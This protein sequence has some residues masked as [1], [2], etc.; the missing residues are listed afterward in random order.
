MLEVHLF[1][2]FAIQHDGKP[3]VLSSRAAQSLFAYLVLRAGSQHRREKLAGMFWPDESEE[4]ARAYLRHELWRIRKALPAVQF[5]HSNDIDISFDPPVQLW[6]DAKLLMDLK[7]SA[8]I[9]ELLSALTACQG[10]FLSGF[11]DEWVLPEREH[12][13]ALYQQAMDRLLALLEHERRWHDILEWAERWISHGEAP[14][15]AYRY[16]M[17][18]YDALGD[19]TR[20]A[21]AYQRC[22]KALQELDL[23]PSEQTRALAFKRS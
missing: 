4:R 21:A 23:Q 13:N 2:T 1:G 3:V 22:V 9:P 11:Y 17:I 8:S 7:E 16:L 19:H 20:V 15:T 18:A 12:M 10:E 6:L 14:E 5:L